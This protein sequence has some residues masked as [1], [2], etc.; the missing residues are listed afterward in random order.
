MAPHEEFSPAL[1]VGPE[2]RSWPLSPVGNTGECPSGAPRGPLDGR[3]WH[4][5]RPVAGAGR[6]LSCCC[7]SECRQSPRRSTWLVLA[8]ELRD[9]THVSL[10]GMAGCLP[11]AEERGPGQG[12]GFGAP[13]PLMRPPWR[14]LPRQPLAVCLVMGSTGLTG[15]A[16]PR[17]PALHAPIGGP[18]VGPHVCK[19][20]RCGPRGHRCGGAGH[21]FLMVSI[22]GAATHP[23]VGGARLWGPGLSGA[24]HRGESH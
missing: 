6:C 18:G 19:A 11:E 1:E 13:S 5:D 8:P 24:C 2:V 22:A 20:C 12:A 9:Y 3:G 15:S 10:G 4:G 7:C 21:P 14:P 17:P 16:E 23:R